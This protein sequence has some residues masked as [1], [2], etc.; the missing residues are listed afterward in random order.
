[1]RLRERERAKELIPPTAPCDLPLCR[2]LNS[3][4]KV[5]QYRRDPERSGGADHLPHLFKAL[6][7]G[8][9]AVF[10]SPAAISAAFG[11]ERGVGI[12]VQ[13]LDDVQQSILDLFAPPA[14][15]GEGAAEPPTALWGLTDLHKFSIC[16]V[17]GRGRERVRQ[18]RPQKRA[19]P[20]TLTYISALFQTP[21]CDVP[22]DHVPRRLNAAGR[23]RRP[24]AAAGRARARSGAAGCLPAPAALGPRLCQAAGAA[25]RRHLGQRAGAGP[26]ATGQVVEREPGR[27]AQ[28]EGGQAAA[29]LPVQGGGVHV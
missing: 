17:D 20:F 27:A 8:V 19:S 22:S 26:R 4:D 21:V 28:R 24:L 6:S 29:V 11:L 9:E 2:L 1:M 3:V 25:A 10:S 13:L 16:Q 5:M 7:T 12:D 18:R 14:A 15:T 23:P